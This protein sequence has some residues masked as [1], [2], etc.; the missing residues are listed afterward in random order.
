[1][2]TLIELLKIYLITNPCTVSKIF[3]PKILK[4]IRKMSIVIWSVAG[5][6]VEIQGATE[7]GGIKGR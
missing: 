6:R 4:F 3:R 5:F 1:M 7:H 2:E